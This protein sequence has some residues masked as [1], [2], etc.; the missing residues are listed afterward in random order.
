MY[1]QL[2]KNGHLGRG[3]SSFSTPA[4]KLPGN[5][6]SLECRHVANV[7]AAFLHRIGAWTAHWHAASDAGHSLLY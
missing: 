6:N 5:L 4:S 3:A 7:C 2:S 1:A